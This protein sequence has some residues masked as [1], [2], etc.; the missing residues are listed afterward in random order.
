MYS[1]VPGGNYAAVIVLLDNW[2][3]HPF[4]QSEII[5]KTVFGL[6]GNWSNR[7]RGRSNVPELGL[8]DYDMMPHEKKKK[9]RLKAKIKYNAHGEEEEI[10]NTERATPQPKQTW[11]NGL[12]YESYE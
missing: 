7:V 8:R 1:Y 5:V 10:A 11:E 3:Y 12:R 9:H 4:W 2:S 6:N